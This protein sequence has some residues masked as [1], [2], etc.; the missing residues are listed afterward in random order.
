MPGE[1]PAGH[2]LLSRAVGNG[3]GQAGTGRAPCPMQLEDRP[4]GTPKAHGKW[5]G[6]MSALS[7]T[8]W[9]PCMGCSCRCLR[10]N[11]GAEGGS[12]LTWGSETLGGTG[13]L[14]GGGQRAH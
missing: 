2:G 14:S 6:E 5:S 10:G 13:V 4:V 8:P 9:T 3:Y 11:S 1:E 7:R 12:Q